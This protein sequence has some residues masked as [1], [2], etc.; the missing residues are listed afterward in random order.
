MRKIILSLIAIYFLSSCSVIMAAKKEGVG[1][2]KIQA[3]YTRGQLIATGATV[4]SGERLETG[5]L[6]EIYRAQK[7]TGSASRAFMHG[8]LDVGTGGIWEV[9]GT[10]IE[11]YS[12]QKEFYFI[13]AVYDENEHIKR[14]ELL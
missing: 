6:V 10:P 12:N 1:I 4:M 9:V 5:E 11:V 13:R 7:E 8:V 2:E 3:C 14:L